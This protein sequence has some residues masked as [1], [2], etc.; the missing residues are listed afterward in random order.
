MNQKSLGIRIEIMKSGMEIMKIF[1]DKKL[2]F[3]DRILK[4]NLKNNNL[5]LI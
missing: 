1:K 5:F 3:Y 4:I 2:N